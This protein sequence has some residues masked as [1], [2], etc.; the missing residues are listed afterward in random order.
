MAAVYRA[1]DELTKSFPTRKFTRH[2]DLIGSIAKV[3]A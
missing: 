1:V 3:A 2:G